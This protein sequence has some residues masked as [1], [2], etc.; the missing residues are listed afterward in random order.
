MS[1]TIDNRRFGFT[2]LEL[3]LVLAIIVALFAI[4]GTAIATYRQKSRINFAESWVGNFGRAL[5]AYSTDHGDYPTTEQGLNALIYI[6]INEGQPMPGMVQPPGY[7]DPNDPNAGMN[8]GA[9]A[10]GG[11]DAFNNPGAMSGMNTIPGAFDPTGGSAT[12]LGG[13]GAMAPM[14]GAMPGDPNMMMGADPNMMMGGM[15]PTGGMPTGYGTGWAQPTF[16]PQ[17]YMQGRKRL[18]PYLTGDKIP[19]DPWGQQYRYEYTLV[20]GVNR[21]TGDRKPAI[22]SAGPDKVDGTDDDIRSWDPQVAA[23]QLLLQQQQM[24]YGGGMGGVDMMGNPLQP[25]MLDGG[26][27]PSMD[28]GMMPPQGGMMP[29]MDGGMMPPQGGMMPPQGGMMPPQGGMMSPQGGMM[30]PQGG[31]M[32]PQG[33]MMPP[34]GGMMPP[35]G[36]GIPPQPPM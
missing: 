12:A 5:E 32:P 27:M 11:P 31:M 7:V 22:W 8:L 13:P 21:L 34:Q 10:L 6:P 18:D 9:T 23:N 25:G 14:P 17:L 24:Q 35:Q 26:M 29:P 3:L 1:K 30:S 4:L 28:G 19:L 20:N 33:G 36:G 16:N 15:D 2:L